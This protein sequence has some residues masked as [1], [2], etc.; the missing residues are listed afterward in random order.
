M[1]RT[2]P[3]ELATEVIEH[4]DYPHEPG[5]LYDCPACEAVCFCNELAADYSITS[6]DDEGPECVACELAKEAHAIEANRK[7]G[8]R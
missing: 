3:C 4:A 1:C 2:A 6:E 5:T 7:Y 8:R